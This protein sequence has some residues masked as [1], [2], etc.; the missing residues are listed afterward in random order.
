[1]TSS[2]LLTEKA[3]EQSKNKSYISEHYAFHYVQD[4][5]AEKEI[6]LI[7]HE[8]EKCFAEICR[9]LQIDYTEKIDYYFTDS[10]IEIGRVLYNEDIPCNGLAICGKNKIYAVYNETER[11][12]GFHEDVHL[13]SFLIGFP[14]SDFLVE[15]LAM[16]FD[17][18]WWRI[19]N[20]AWTAFYMKKHDGL[21]V[22]SLLDNDT[23]ARYDCSITYPVA[24]SFTEFLINRYGI[25]LYIQLYKYNGTQYEEVFQAVFNASLSEIEADFWNN[26]SKISVDDDILEEIL[27]NENC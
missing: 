26:I 11:C 27:K 3:F 24:G 25:E 23:F 9:V 6:T 8:Q 4:S 10:P 19:N 2:E 17:A 5:L 1:M 22:K 12:I 21:S 13:I 20:E 15:G 18:T 7:A 14:A 16:F